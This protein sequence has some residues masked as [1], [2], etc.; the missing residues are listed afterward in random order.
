MDLH[1]IY[2]MKCVKELGCHPSQTY[3][4][5]AYYPLSRATG[6]TCSFEDLYSSKAV[7]QHRGRPSRV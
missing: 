1:G 7:Q 4:C 3:K 6:C 5:V 2:V